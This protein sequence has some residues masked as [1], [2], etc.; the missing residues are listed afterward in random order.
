M[1]L[2]LRQ[3]VV[4]VLALAATVVGFYAVLVVWASA[5]MRCP[6]PPDAMA[7]VPLGLI[8]VGL[9]VSAF[10]LWHRPRPVLS[11]VAWGMLA[12]WILLAVLMISLQEPPVACGLH[13]R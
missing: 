8:V 11:A 6:G 5:F 4:A 7:Y 1:V 12:G 13:Q 9:L 10:M 2:R 3:A